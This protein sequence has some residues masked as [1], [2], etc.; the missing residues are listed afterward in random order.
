MVP[1][2]PVYDLTPIAPARFRIEGAPEG[3]LVQ[4]DLAEDKV[5]S[6]TLVQGSALSLVLLPK[7]Q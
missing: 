1:G 7:Q 2:Q 6:M 4:F 5:K 3:F